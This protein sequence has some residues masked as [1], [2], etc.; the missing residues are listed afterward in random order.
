MRNK[1][2]KRLKKECMTHEEFKI[3]KLRGAQSTKGKSIIWA[4]GSPMNLY[5]LSKRFYK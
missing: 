4:P 2:A 5:R 3:F 1:V